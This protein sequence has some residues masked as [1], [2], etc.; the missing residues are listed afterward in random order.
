MFMTSARRITAAIG[1]TTIAAVATLAFGVQPA[2]AAASGYLLSKGIGSIYSK[3][4]VVAIG[5]I[6][7]GTA[8]TTYYKIVNTA[9]TAETFKVTL[10]TFGAGLTATLY[11]GFKAVPN[12]YTTPA[13]APGKTLS[14]KV[15]MTLAA[16]TPQGPPSST[17]ALLELHDPVSNVELD[18]SAAWANATNQTGTTRNDLFLK[19]GAQPFVGGSFGPQIE[20]SNAIKV[21]STATFVLRLKNDGATPAAISLARQSNVL[22]PSNFSTTVKQGT[23]DVTA[24]VSTGSYTTGT[25]APGAKKE[26]KVLIKLVSATT[27][28]YM[29]EGF[30]ASGPDGSITQLAH[31]IVGV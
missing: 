28:D 30:T 27:C 31:V 6:P 18:E 15:K 1:T 11:N 10:G 24:A 2:N 14:L 8:K 21:G 5:V 19:T 12:V 23:Q 9:S 26:L 22:C 25:L 20:T 29:Y 17:T 16:G 3:S 7:G 13:I 4:D